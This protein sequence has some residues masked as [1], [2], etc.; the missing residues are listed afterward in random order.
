MELKDM[1]IEELEARKS[2]IAAELDA[3]GADL[4]ALEAEARGINAELENRKAL[5]AQ[6]AEIREQVA[7]GEGEVIE[8]IKTEE[9]KIMSD[10]EVRS[11]KEYI[12]AYVDYIKGKND[13]SECRAM[14]T[15]NVSG[16]VPVPTY[17]ADR[18]QTAWEND[19]IMSRVKRTFIKGNLKQGVEIEAGR[20]MPH[21][22]GDDPVT[23]EELV[24]AIVNIVPLTVKKW[25]S[26]STEV[27]DLD[28]QAFLDYLYDEIAYQIVQGAAALVLDAI[29]AAPTSI[30]TPPEPMKAVKSIETLALGDI[31][32]AL[33]ELVGDVRN[34][35]F[36]ANRGTIAAYQALALAANYSVDIWGGTTVIATDLLPS[37]A[38]ATDDQ[39]F[40]F[41]GDLGAIHANYP[42]GADVKFV[43]DE[44]TLAD[45]D[46]VRIIGRQM[47]GVGYVRNMAF[48]E[49]VKTDNE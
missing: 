39:P 8:T 33:G 23:E 25:I 22:E 34:P 47:V 11:S 19:E 17:I 13:G 7:Q 24:L 36:I 6:K 4:N 46:L 12:D 38:T 31:I 2:A 40:A 15:E 32:E 1:T 21:I 48:V 35:V 37:F 10:K 27:L 42:N 14:L 43:F 16:T 20:A 5:E 26:V 28:G 49:M 41:V 3:D 30:T 45:S 29:D 44:Y 9:R 18:I